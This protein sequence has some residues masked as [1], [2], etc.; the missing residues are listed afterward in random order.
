MTINISKQ[1]LIANNNISNTKTITSNRCIHVPKYI[2]NM[3][4]NYPNYNLFNDFKYKNISADFKNCISK[5]DAKYSRLTLHGLRHS[6]A[7]YLLENKMDIKSIQL[8]LGH[9]DIS[10]TTNTYTHISNKLNNMN[11]VIID[12]MGNIFDTIFDTKLK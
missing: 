4:I 10:T 5:L 7:S 11:N 3:L 2:V 1:K 6:Y 8:L 9:S 12:K